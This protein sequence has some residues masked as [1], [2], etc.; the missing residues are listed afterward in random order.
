[1]N[2][3]IKT[4]FWLIIEENKLNIFANNYK[5]HFINRIQLNFSRK[6]LKSSHLDAP[7][8]ANKNEKTKF[9]TKKIKKISDCSGFVVF[10]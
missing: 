2:F 3:F 10:F 6:Q 5:S 7:K 8:L 4:R 9:I 1:M